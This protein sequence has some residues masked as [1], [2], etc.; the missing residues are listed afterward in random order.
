VDFKFPE[1]SENKKI[2]WVVHIDDKTNNETAAY[3]M[4]VGLDLMAELG[5]IIDLENK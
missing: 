3:D 2:E 5:L 4:I 1:L